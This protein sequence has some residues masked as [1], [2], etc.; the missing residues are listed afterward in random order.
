MREVGALLDARAVQGGRTARGHLRWLARAGGI[1]P[2]RVEEL[3][4]LV[5]LAEVAGRRIGGFSLGMSQR[6]GIAAALL[7]D[8]AVVL[9]DE[10]GNGLDP[11]GVLW[12]RTLLRRL[13]GEGRV[14][15][16]SSHQMDEMQHSA[17]HVLVLGRGRLIAD[18]DIDSFTRAA[19]D[20]G[21]RVVSP[22]ADALAAALAAEGAAVAAAPGGVLRVTGITAERIG[23]L[24]AARGLRLHE[25][26]PRRASLEAAFVELTRDSVQYATAPPPPPPPTPTPPAAD[27][28]VAAGHPGSER[29][30]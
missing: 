2:A 25:L 3:L 27:V 15:L 30:S 9:L 18:S 5:G 13:A 17:D 20:G 7:G 24:A 10:P 28:P 11:E 6:L 8:P 1:G 21:V 16:V 4:G 14:V 26:T 19:G 23:D 29:S 22:D 12:V